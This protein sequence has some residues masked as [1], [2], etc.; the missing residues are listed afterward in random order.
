MESRKAMA[1][2]LLVFVFIALSAAVSSSKSPPDCADILFKTNIQEMVDHP[3]VFDKPLPTWLKGT[4]VS[5][6]IDLAGEN[7]VLNT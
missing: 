1:P 7:L 4:L 6:A 5:C 3:I 2:A